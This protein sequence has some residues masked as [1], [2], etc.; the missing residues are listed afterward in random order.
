MSAPRPRERAGLLVTNLIK[1]S[2]IVVVM[3]DLARNDLQA[4]HIAL[5]AFMMAGA[6]SL[7]SLLGSMFGG[8]KR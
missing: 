1:L 6:T 8:E 3:V 5:A 4:S 2:G 7:E